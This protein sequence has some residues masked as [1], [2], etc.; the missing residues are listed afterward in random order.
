MCL[1]PFHI[2]KWTNE[3]LDRV[4][5]TH[6]PAP[7]KTARPT[8]PSS[9][10]PTRSWR[11]LRGALRAGKEN[12]DPDRRRLINSLRRH[13]YMLWRA[14]ELKEQLRDLYRKT[15]RRRARAYLKTWI[16]AALRARIG[17][18]QTL[19]LRLRKPFKPIAA[20]VEHGLSNSRAEGI[21]SKI[22]VIQ[23]RGYGHPSPDSPT[24][25]IH[26]CLGAIT[27]TLPTQT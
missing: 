20:A 10:A 11:R 23:R 4:Y 21:N 15:P 18:L 27:I 26:L 25:M 2:I 14:W 9:N 24:N 22:R 16:T 1:D 5:Q 12:L 19:A 8:R 3:A 7:P 6:P 13:R 17:P